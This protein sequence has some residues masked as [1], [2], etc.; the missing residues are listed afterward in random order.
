MMARSS[1]VLSVMRRT[2]GRG[3]GVVIESAIST[4][5]ALASPEIDLAVVSALLNLNLYDCIHT[6]RDRY[7]LSIC[8]HLGKVEPMCPYN[9]PMIRS[10][11]MEG[12]N[13]YGFI[14]IGCL[15]L[16]K[17]ERWMCPTCDCYYCF[18]CVPKNGVNEG[19]NSPRRL[20]SFSISFIFSG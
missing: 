7:S 9:H 8:L 18:A 15:R 6:R 10:A 13:K 14:C 12:R 16:K 11:Y 19:K 17:T 5:A 4:S 2:L 3:G 1:R 20:T